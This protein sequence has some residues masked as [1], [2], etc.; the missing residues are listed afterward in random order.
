MKRKN[1][2]CFDM[3][4]TFVDLYGVD[5]WR[6]DLVCGR[7]RPYAEAEPLVNLSLFARLLN[8]LQKNGYAICVVSWGAKDAT[9]EYLEEIGAVKRGWLM[10]H[11]ASVQFDGIEILP[12][13]TPKWEV[14]GNYGEAILFDDEEKN[15]NEWKGSAFSP[16]DMFEILKE[17]LH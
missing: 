3:D 13:G 16:E 10:Q 2:L 8:R 15:R 17:L 11:L 4:G 5:G 1:V 12:Y 9:E 14:V 6:S 7:T